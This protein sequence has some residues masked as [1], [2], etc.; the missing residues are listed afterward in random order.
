MLGSQDSPEA[1]HTQI[2]L[3]SGGAISCQEY[4]PS[5]GFAR[6]HE[7]NVVEG[8]HYY[9]SVPGS[10]TCSAELLHICLAVLVVIQLVASV[11][12]R[13][14][15]LVLEQT[16]GLNILQPVLD[17]EVQQQ[18]FS[19]QSAGWVLLTLLSLVVNLW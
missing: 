17:T 7:T 5:I 19:R 1:S 8:F 11:Q 14:L 6:Q 15:G 10:V 4:H 18:P 9:Y 2:K 16:H 13:P 12:G 3:I